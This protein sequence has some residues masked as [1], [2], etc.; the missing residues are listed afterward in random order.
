MGADFHCWQR[1]CICFSTT[2]SCHFALRGAATTWPSALKRRKSARAEYALANSMP[3][4]LARALFYCAKPL[5][6]CRPLPFVS[7][8]GLY[9]P[10]D[11]PCVINKRQPFPSAPEGGNACMWTMYACT[12][13]HA[14]MRSSL[15]CQHLICFWTCRKA[16]ALDGVY[17]FPTAHYVHLNGDIC[18]FIA[19]QYFSVRLRRD[20]VLLSPSCTFIWCTK[21]QWGCLKYEERRWAQRPRF[22]HFRF[23]G[24]SPRLRTGDS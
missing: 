17:H 5:P 12:S 4:W 13:L 24:R 14:H 3:S 7:P 23:V 15:S 9:A 20:E 2:Q 1:V 18:I 10:N 8:S 22:E 19:L 16:A 6:Q 21:R 11:L